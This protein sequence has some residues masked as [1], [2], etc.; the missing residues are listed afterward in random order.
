MA[1]TIGD[2]LRHL[3]NHAP[4]L[5]DDNRAE[6]LEAIDDAFSETAADPQPEKPELPPPPGT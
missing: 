4:D 5:S 6:H 2:V 3:V 1:A